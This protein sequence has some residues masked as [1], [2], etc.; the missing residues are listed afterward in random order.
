MPLSAGLISFE[1][2][3]CFVESNLPPMEI[4][5]CLWPNEI[6]LLEELWPEGLRDA[7]V[8]GFTNAGQAH[9]AAQ[10]CIATWGRL[11]A[12]QVQGTRGERC[13]HKRMGSASQVAGNRKTFSCYCGAA[14]CP[15]GPMLHEGFDASDPRWQVWMLLPRRVGDLDVD[16]QW[17]KL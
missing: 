3:F 7:Q 5:K 13:A 9:V 17:Q 14:I 2:S 4:Q 6:A 16:G 12:A 8:L 15:E 10:L 1:S 11:P